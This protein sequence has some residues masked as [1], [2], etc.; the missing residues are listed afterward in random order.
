MPRTAKT[1]AIDRIREIAHQ[2]WLDAGCPDGESEAHWLAAE[3]LAAAEIPAKTATRKTAATAKA[4]GATKA[5]AP[6]SAKA[7][8]PARTRRSSKTA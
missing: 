4:P 3:A 6:G 1:P 8:A 5:K 2:I 7:E